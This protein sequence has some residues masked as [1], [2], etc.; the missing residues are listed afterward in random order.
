MSRQSSGSLY[1]NY[2]ESLG[3]T[4]GLGPTQALISLSER[5]ALQLPPA[6]QV[7]SED[8]AGSMEQLEILLSAGDGMEQSARRVIYNGDGAGSM[9]SR[10][11]MTPHRY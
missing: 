6:G 5:F 11:Y 3:G 8:D 4:V 9:C 10:G 2:L 1:N 7:E